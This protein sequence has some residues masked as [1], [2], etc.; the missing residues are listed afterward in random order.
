[1]FE[2]IRN[3]L[4]WPDYYSLMLW[5]L[6]QDTAYRAPMTFDEKNYMYV[7]HLSCILLACE[8]ALRG[9]LAARQE[10]EGEVATTSLEFEFH[11]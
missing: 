7:L 6:S 2:S 8:Q 1:M 3:G 10:K 9:T 5:P 4:D 11:L